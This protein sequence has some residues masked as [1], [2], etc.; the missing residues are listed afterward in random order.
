MVSAGCNWWSSNPISGLTF[1]LFWPQ[2]QMANHHHHKPSLPLKYFTQNYL[3][4]FLYFFKPF[5]WRSCSDRAYLSNQWLWHLVRPWAEG[6]GGNIKCKQLPTAANRYQNWENH[7]RPEK[8]IPN[9]WKLLTIP[10][11]RK[12]YLTW[13]KDIRP[14][15]LQETLLTVCKKWKTNSCVAC[16]YFIHRQLFAL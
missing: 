8:T 11:L 7:T 14:E 4:V 15:K 1:C 10:D 3:P 6:G 2:L 12:P 5:S 16:K 9:L 13:E